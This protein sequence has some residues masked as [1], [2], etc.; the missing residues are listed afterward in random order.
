MAGY[1]QDDIR[2][3]Q[4]LAEQRNQRQVVET[5][6]EAI[7]RPVTAP[8][9]AATGQ[10]PEGFDNRQDE[11]RAAVE[12]AEPQ[13]RDDGFVTQIGEGLQ[14][15]ADQN[16]LDPL[17]VVNATAALMNAAAPD[18]TPGKAMLQGLDDAVPSRAEF[19][20]RAEQAAA[21]GNQLAVGQVIG[22]R[23]EGWCVGTADPDRCCVESGHPMVSHTRGDQAESCG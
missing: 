20:E 10:K 4:D 5:E 12:A 9:P 16:P 21:D 19:N 2:K 22:S 18:G 8:K 7:E 13:Q 11:I 3:L 6:Q 1:S 14:Y 17:N 23:D 15:L